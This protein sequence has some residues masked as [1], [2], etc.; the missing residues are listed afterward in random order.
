MSTTQLPIETKIA[1]VGKSYSALYF[2]A[3]VVVYVNGG[4]KVYKLLDII[5][6]IAVSHDLKPHMRHDPTRWQ[7]I[8]RLA[9]IYRQSNF[10]RPIYKYIMVSAV[11]AS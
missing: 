3:D 8:F 6:I 11:K 4:A 5:E 1:T 9:L 7:H 10:C 2:Q